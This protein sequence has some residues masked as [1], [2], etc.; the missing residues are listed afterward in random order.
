ME[1]IIPALTRHLSFKASLKKLPEEP[2]IYI[3]F[4]SDR[5]IYIGKAV[6]LKNRI[7]S[8]FLTN[9]APKTARMF[10]EANEFSII[11]VQTELDSLLLEAKLVHE[12]KP[13]YNA[14][15]KD[16]KHPLYIRITKEKY[17]RIITARKIEEGEA[18]IAF[19]G[20]FPSSS[21]V[22]SVLRMLRRIF[23]FSEHKL[24]KRPC[25]YS[26]IK[27]C[28]PC[29]NEIEKKKRKTE[30]VSLRNTY[31]KNIRN[32]KRVLERKTD[33]VLVDL[34]KKMAEYSKREDFEGAA[35]IRD[36]IKK[37][38]YISQPILPT[39]SF[40]EN[41]NLVEDL[42][43]EELKALKET[44]NRNSELNLQK[45]ER[46]ECFDVSHL[47][48]ISVTASMVTFINGAADKNFY[49]HFKIRQK[50][51][52]NDV[53]SMKEVITRRIRNLDKWGRPD[54]I[55]V[56]GG[57]GQVG[58]FRDVLSKEKIPVIGLAK[59]FE[60]LIIPDSSGFKEIRLKA[61][62]ALHLAQRI[63]NEAHRFARRYHHKLLKDYLILKK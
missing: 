29:P 50:D 62:P 55:I 59:Q 11:Q 26:H 32:I 35:A 10:K 30:R 46:I 20:P 18:N 40:L 45:L 22:R 51:G 34:S 17:P 27:L 42:R 3:F 53:S 60:T 9:L 19:Y 44:I 21:S 36:Q 49:R 8:Y 24:G 52:G 2:G 41:P 48:G 37:L 47:A 6:N 13:R 28:S 1:K 63:R 4:S 38:E 33:S 58:V 61:S 12:L 54:L 43:Q 16:D 7:S 56:D 57:K 31:L 15:L 23:P 25:L 14:T 39:G 5:P